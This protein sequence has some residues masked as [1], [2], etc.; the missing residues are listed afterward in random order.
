M[1]PSATLQ[2]RKRTQWERTHFG[3]RYSWRSFCVLKVDGNGLGLRRGNLSISLVFHLFLSATLYIYIHKVYIHRSVCAENLFLRAIFGTIFL[4][5]QFLTSS[6]DQG[7]YP[8]LHA[9]QLEESERKSNEIE[10]LLGVG[11]ERT[12]S[13]QLVAFNLQS[14]NF[15]SC[16]GWTMATEKCSF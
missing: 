3:T 6:A 13:F 15:I 10:N 16:S 1:R 14:L 8:W 9:N 2:V 11:C 12:K 4:T 7:P 5:W